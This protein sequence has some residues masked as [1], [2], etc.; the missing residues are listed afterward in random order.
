MAV[1]TKK[2]PV[3]IVQTQ[4]IHGNKKV[5]VMIDLGYYLDT[6]VD[7]KEK[8]EKFKKLYFETVT[9]ARKLFYGSDE[10]GKKY[11][12]IPSS[13]YMNLAI[14][15]R[16]FN[17]AIEN[18]FVI[19]NYTQALHRDF[20]LSRDYVQDLL[21]ISKLFKKTQIL[22]SVPFSYYRALMRKSNEL[23]KYNMFDDELIRLNKMGKIKTLSGRENYKKELIQVLKQAT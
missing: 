2:I 8:I 18:E 21:V 17:E 15:L 16:K 12:K 1:K 5:G 19:T 20:G 6:K 23:K 22:D 14:I 3:K 9:K 11:Q 4:D 7:P 10:L 13:T